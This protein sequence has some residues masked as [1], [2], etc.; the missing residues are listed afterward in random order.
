MLEKLRKMLLE[1]FQ[2]QMK[3]DTGISTR[4]NLYMVEVQLL[5]DFVYAITGNA[6]LYGEHDDEIHDACCN[7]IDRMHKY[8]C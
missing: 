5:K 7:F 2:R 6:Q 8:D 4:M 3:S 1:M